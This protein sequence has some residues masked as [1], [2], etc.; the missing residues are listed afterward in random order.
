M[1]EVN[2]P[3]I[4]RKIAGNE[5]EKGCLAGSVRSDDSL[6]RALLHIEADIVHRLQTAETAIQI[7]YFKK[8]HLFLFPACFPLLL[9]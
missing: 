2:F 1:I 5:I 9:L 3:G 8:C 4:C 7:L 6:Y